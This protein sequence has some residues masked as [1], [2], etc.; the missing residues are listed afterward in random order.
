MSAPGP[1]T[2]AAARRPDPAFWSHRRVAVTGA[3]GFLGSH[4]VDELVGLGA[5]VVILRRDV[6]AP[7][8]LTTGW[9]SK[10]DVVEGDLLDQAL[11]ERLLGD[12]EVR[13]V[14]HLAA[15]SQVGAANRNPVATFEANIAGTWSLLEAVRRSPTVGQVV[16]ASSDKAYGDQAALPYTEDA[17][18]A[19]VHPYDVSKACADQIAVCYARVFGVPVSITRCGNFFGPV[20]PTGPGSCP[21][22]SAPCWP[23]SH[24]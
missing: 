12:Y 18:L 5:D 19:A 13:T 2:P 9:W 1:T 24:R 23:G 8:A 11:C 6:V 4:M 21:A 16:I 10:V 22:P 15:Q 20:T 14:L 3:T 17:P 7:T